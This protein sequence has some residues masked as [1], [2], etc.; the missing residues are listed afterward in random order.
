[1]SLSPSDLRLPQRSAEEEL[2]PLR[3]RFSHDSDDSLSALELLEGAT[4]RGLHRGR[5]LS[6]SSF[7]FER[8][9]LPLS[10]SVS[11]PDEVRSASGEKS[12]G[13]INGTLELA[14]RETLIVRTIFL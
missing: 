14:S 11:E 7:R 8:D 10:A 3:S 1:M 4:P 6:G 9:L 13:L 2:S 5:S 12:I